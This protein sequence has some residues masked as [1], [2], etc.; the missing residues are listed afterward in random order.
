[1]QVDYLSPQETGYKAIKKRG[2]EDENKE[3]TWSRKRTSCRKVDPRKRWK[4]W[5]VKKSNIVIQQVGKAKKNPRVSS[6]A[7]KKT[8]FLF[9]VQLNV[10]QMVC[11]ISSEPELPPLAFVFFLIVVIIIKDLHFSFFAIIFWLLKKESESTNMFLINTSYQDW[12]GRSLVEWTGYRW[13][14]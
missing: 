11:H 14:A 12:I 13:G 10:K 6:N 4:K 3:R 9:Y 2:R 7:E 1:M 8:Q 5:K